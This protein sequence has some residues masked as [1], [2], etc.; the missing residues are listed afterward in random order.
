MTNA[1]HKKIHF[2]FL[3]RQPLSRIIL[4]GLVL[5]MVGIVSFG[6]FTRYQ[7]SGLA[8]QTAKLYRHPYAVGL[9]LRDI[10]INIISMHRSM[11]D[12]ALARDSAEIDKAS[13]IVDQLE[14]NAFG[15]FDVVRERFLG[16]PQMVTDAY[17]AFVDWKAIRDE[18]IA[19]RRAGEVEAA[20]EITKEKGAD[21]VAKI[22]GALTAL[23]DFANQKGDEFYANSRNIS[24]T[25]LLI[26]LLALAG[27]A[28]VTA[29]T[30]ALIVRSVGYRLNRLQGSM[31]GLAGGELETG[32]PFSGFRTESG[33]MAAAL[34]VFR[35]NAVE[36]QR[37][38]GEAE[39]TRK[40]T[41]SE[42]R[43]RET[44]KAR[45]TSLMSEAVNSLGAGLKRLSEGDLS[46]SID[47][48]FIESLEV[49]RS[50]F[51]DSVR[52]LH[53]TM[54]GISG[55]TVSVNEG[56][57]ELQASV[58]DLSRRTEQQ[59]ASLEETTAAFS[60]ITT[61]V[62]ESS[63][64]AVDA[65]RITGVAK[66]ETEKSGEVVS[67][68]VDAMS[69]IESAS[70]EISQII[71]VIDEIA[72][73]TNL[74]ALNAGVEAARAGEAGKG[75]AVVA[76]EVRELAQRSASAAKDIK[77]LINKSSTEVES[78]VELV[79][80]TGDALSKIAA[81]VTEINAH[82]QAIADSAREQSVSLKEIGVTMGQMD[83]MTQ[84]N[85]AMVEEVTAVT[86]RF[87]DDADSIARSVR[88]FRLGADEPAADPAPRIAGS[89]ETAAASPARKMISAVS[90]AFGGK[91]AQTAV[92]Q[93]W[94][95]F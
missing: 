59:A 22:N 91:P 67:N 69:R 44:E 79:T 52:K 23:L 14:Q 46:V 19:L 81:H 7:M 68:A 16:N 29:A 85:A 17:T 32:I 2:E 50:D 95:E 82:I 39:D 42:R 64:R 21:H 73:Q 49:L 65:A 70:A 4:A 72:F 25:S 57:R 60:E 87:S 80:A 58:S 76:Q 75:F 36:R 15:H 43:E 28:V 55:G 6:L 61:T 41:E 35:D 92:G 13:A 94:E 12:V 53:T 45:E 31:R 84:K 38:E 56:A 83:E 9:N 54:Q 24:D 3:D 51:N 86:H 74:L 89:G 40:L 63:E 93:D 47:E 90:R 66:T 77:S 1:S 48:P 62:T 71:N 18:V 11:K 20:A 27:I 26:V 37:L 5:I 30:G 78:G 33:N 34:T 10:K 8:T 88:Q